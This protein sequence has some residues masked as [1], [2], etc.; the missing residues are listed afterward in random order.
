MKDEALEREP[1]SCDTGQDGPVDL[2]SFLACLERVGNSPEQVSVHHLIDA[3]GSRS[4]GPMILLPGVLAISPLTGIPG[5]ATAIAVFVMLVSGQ[6]LLGRDHFWLPRWVLQRNVSRRKL[7]KSLRLLQKPAR[8]VD[9]VVKSRMRVLTSRPAHFVTALLCILIAA[10]M[11]VL[12]LVPFANTTAGLALTS[13]AL[14]LIARDGL[15]FL[16]ALGFCSG[17]VWFILELLV[18]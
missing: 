9:K 3:I 11:P 15:L 13:F 16:L 14:S 2:Q 5:I 6:L 12:D 8:W 7:R 1:V 10:T 18:I 17:I 4:F